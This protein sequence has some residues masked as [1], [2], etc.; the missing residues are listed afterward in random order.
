MEDG[1]LLGLQLPKRPIYEPV[2]VNYSSNLKK[3]FD[4][5]YWQVV[6]VE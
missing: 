5:P 3:R 2:F 1:L 6:F 4:P